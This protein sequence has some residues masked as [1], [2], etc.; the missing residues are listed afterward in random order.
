MG[1]M[2]GMLRI[3]SMILQKKLHGEFSWEG[4]DEDFEQGIS[5]HTKQ[6]SKNQ[7]ATGDTLW[8]CTAQ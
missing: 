6:P 4:G 5:L 2:Y 8:Y 3:N 7:D 1:P